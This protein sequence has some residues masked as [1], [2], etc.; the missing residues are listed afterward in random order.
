MIP[1][2]FLLVLAQ[3]TTSQPAV[4]SQSAQPAQPSPTPQQSEFLRSL[5]SIPTA[6][7]LREW[8]DLLGSEPHVAGT[9]GDAREIKRLELAFAAMG[10]EVETHEFWPLL[11]HP[12][13][14]RLEIVEDASASNATTPATTPAVSGRRGVLSV[15][16]KNLAEDPAAAHPDLPWGWNA[17]SASGDVTAE[18]AYVNYGTLEDFARLKEL[19]VD[20]KGKIVI[21]R[22]GGNFRGYKAKF[23]EEAG[24]VGLIIYID[25]ADSGFKKGDVYPAG[26]WANDS[27][28]QRGSIVSLPYPGDPLTPG[29]PATKDATR[30]DPNA[31]NLPRIPVQ[32]IGYGAAGK[33]LALMTGREVPDA[34]WRGGLEMPYRLEGGPSLKL[35]MKVEQKRAVLPTAN[36]IARLK[37]TANDGSV[38]IVGCHH[39]AW[40]FGAADPLAGTIVL[41]ETARAFSECAAKGLRPRSDVLFCAWGAE[42]YGII[43]SVEWV[44]AH[45]GELAK[46]TAYV[47]LDM[48]SMGPNLGVTSSASIQTAVARACGIEPASVGAV[49]GG[50][51]HIGFLF[52]CG[53][54]SVTIGAGGAPGTSYHSNYDTLAWYRKTVGEDY[55]SAM[56][57][58]RAALATMAAF[59]QYE[60]PAVSS[61]ALVASI[62]KN[63]ADMKAATIGQSSS[64]IDARLA[65]L[66]RVD[67]CFAALEDG[68][69]AFDALIERARADANSSSRGSGAT[70]ESL[71]LRARA[72]DRALLDIDGV[73][74]RPW[75]R[76]LAIASDKDSG[77]RG[78]SIP[79]LA[80]AVDGPSITAAA[81]RLCVCATRLRAILD[82]HGTQA[83]E[84]LK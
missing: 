54:P 52:R 3:A 70:A 33:I 65:A 63:C 42:E 48:A 59:T 31:I 13:S 26:T 80:D 66:D 76:N 8:H 41:M 17:Y 34:S 73:V 75:F 7:K 37:G 47:N 84:I 5:E 14:A 67:A 38:V 24:A 2:L 21:A 20:L 51:D 32:P 22:Y 27:C 61:S 23:A 71:A 12:V 44:E 1:T 16:E 36:V 58:T 77:Y 46:A 56:L 6:A 30:L 55:A 28:I 45:E 35:H 43:G 60:V 69:S 39:D 25:P 19:G 15:I 64:L 9:A 68:A 4:T 62:R 78:T 11:S 53:V 29:I 81:D 79:S 49:G 74:G 72:I 50:S 10:L 57:V 83:A 82:Y 18:V 40:G